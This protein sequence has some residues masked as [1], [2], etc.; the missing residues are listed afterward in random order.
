MS[1]NSDL[2]LSRRQKVFVTLE[3]VVGTLKFP[4]AT[5]DFIHPAGN[6]V[7]NQNPA[8]VNSE[9]LSDTLDLLNQFQNA[10]PAGEWTLKMYVRPA[11]CGNGPQG[12]TL[13]RSLQGLVNPATVASFAS[14]YST[15]ATAAILIKGISGGILP[16]RGV[17]KAGSEKIYY[18]GKTQVY[19]GTTA[20]LTSCTR[21]YENTT[22]A[23]Y[24]T[25]ST[26]SLNS[27]FYRQYATSE[28]FSLWI[29]TDHFVQAMAGCS[30]NSANLEITNEGGLLMTFTGGGMSMKWAGSSLLT[31][32]YATTATAV[33]VQEGKN[34][35]VGMYVYNS[36]TGLGKALISATNGTTG[37]LTF[38]DAIG[39]TWAS[40]ATVKG[41][42]PTGTEVGTA[43]EAKDSVA[44]VDGVLT[45]IKKTSLNVGT[46]KQYLIDEIGTT[47][48]VD[49][50]ENVRDINASLNLYFRKS[51]AQHFKAG[52]AGNEVIARLIFGNVEGYMMDM[53]LKRVK[54][55]VPKINFTPPAIELQMPMKAL[56]VHGEDSLEIVFR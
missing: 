23:N 34:Y 19:G 35:S 21:G 24:A 29:E 54:L 41:F 15:T 48:P 28:S 45:K 6:A 18:N 40:G 16:E 47:A 2:G 31:A 52:Y 1:R 25:N 43:I 10:T 12:A 49:F 27:V 11:G 51:D 39:S 55:E 42:T 30:I 17:M 13:F 38:T 3:D 44:Y 33:I 22:A 26:L 53:Y 14:N 46:P 37:K 8:F 20:T 36:T 56:G 4:N 50:I 7:M 9:E 32:A 5:T